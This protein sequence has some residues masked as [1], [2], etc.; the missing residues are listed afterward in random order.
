MDEEVSPYTAQR[1]AQIQEN[2]A[3][4]IS[5]NLDRDEIVDCGASKEAAS[6]STNVIR[7]RSDTSAD[8]SQS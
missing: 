1:E 6:Q 4:A 8:G 7:P 5:L 3:M 2:R